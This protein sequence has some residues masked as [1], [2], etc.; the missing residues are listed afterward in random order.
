MTKTIFTRLTLAVLFM[1]TVFGSANLSLAQSDLADS[2]RATVLFDLRLGKMRDGD[3]MA[4]MADKMAEVEEMIPAGEFDIKSLDRIFGAM[5]LPDDMAGFEAMQQGPEGIEFFVTLKFNSTDA[6]DDLMTT[7]EGDSEEVEIGG[8]TFFKPP[9][10]ENMLAHRV[11]ETTIEIGSPMYL[12]QSTRRLFTAGLAEAFKNTPDY[13]IRICADLAGESGLVQEIMEQA[14]AESGG[15]A[16]AGTMIDMIDN[17]ANL[18]ISMDF[19]SENLLSIHAKGVSED[20]AEELRGGLDGIL[21]MAKFGGMNAVNEI[22]DP[23]LKE[24]A[25]GILNSLAAKREGDEVMIDIPRPE[26]L[27]KAA[28][29][30]VEM[31]M[32]MMMGGMGADF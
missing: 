5:T 7:I 11:D 13:G 22:P 29:A 10:V 31:G 14:K 21:G 20:D 18:R 2:D 3:F 28:E 27:E 15:D 30:M 25:G 4:S 6:A 12:Q 9:E 16:M 23:E 1:A 8:A 19:D 32:G 17:A 26:K 24:V